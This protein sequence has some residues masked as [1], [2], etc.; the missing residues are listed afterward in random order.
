MRKYLLG[1]EVR[2]VVALVTLTGVLVVAVSRK[3][4]KVL[5]LCFRKY[6]TDH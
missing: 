2:A 4:K 5:S 6:E 3:D 1:V